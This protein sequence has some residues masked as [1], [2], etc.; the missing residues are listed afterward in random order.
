MGAD[1]REAR[2]EVFDRYMDLAGD[3]PDSMCASSHSRGRSRS[4][5]RR[6]RPDHRRLLLSA[7][8]AVSLT[9]L[10]LIVA[11]ASAA[12]A[13]RWCGPAVGGAFNQRVHGI[14]C[15]YGQVVTEG[16]LFPNARRTRQGSFRCARYRQGQLW[17]YTCLRSGGTQG[18]AFNTY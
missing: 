10:L 8:A 3:A 11:G 13:S 1:L 9:T 4:L 16:G 5:A 18:L 12:S 15:G 14:S 6:I 2:Q 17:A 7:V